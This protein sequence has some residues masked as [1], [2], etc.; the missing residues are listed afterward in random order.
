[1]IKKLLL[2]LYIWPL[3]FL[4]T[5]VA[6]LLIP[7]IFTVNLLFVRKPVNS[8][9]R[10]GVRV[11]GWVLVRL[12]PFFAPVRLHDRSGGRPET[13]IYVANHNS[14]A[15][16]YCFGVIPG[17]FVFFTSWPFNI[18]VYNW[19]MKQAEYLNTGWGWQTLYEKSVRLLKNGCS[20]II[21]PEGHRSRTGELANFENGAFRLASETGFP[22]VPVCITGTHRLMPPGQRFLTPSRVSVTI[23]PPHHPPRGRSDRQ[24]I[25]Q[26]KEQVRETFDREL[27]RQGHD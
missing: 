4:V 9:F 1:M 13:G 8:L 25:Q 14:S 21:W 24:S 27:L 19:I 17:E 6:L 12:V 10:I 2:N 15:D 22:I 7:I 5:L 18:P 26:L 20:L 11:Y 16:P 3:F 23:L